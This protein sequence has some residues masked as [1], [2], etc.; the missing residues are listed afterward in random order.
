[1]WFYLLA[2]CL[3]ACL[4]F[5]QSSILNTMDALYNTIVGSLFSL[6]RPVRIFVACRFALPPPPPPTFVCLGRRSPPLSSSPLLCPQ[7]PTGGAERERESRALEGKGPLATGPGSGRQCAR[8]DRNLA[9]VR[10]HQPTFPPPSPPAWTREPAR[11]RPAPPHS[12]STLLVSC[13]M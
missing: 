8:P 5:I 12:L 1:M 2:S 4:L 13:C 11:L 10:P 6:A 9:S 7:L 3:L